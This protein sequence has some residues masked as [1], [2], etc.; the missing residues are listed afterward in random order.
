MDLST[1][2]VVI[3]AGGRGARFDHETQ[4]KP[5][6]MIEVCGKP[7]LEHIID[8]FVRQGFRE[9]WIA[10]G[11]LVEQIFEFF[12]EREWDEFES[13][14]YRRDFRFDDVRIHVVDTGELSHTGERVRIVAPRDSR[15][16]LTYGDGLSDVNMRD[17]IAQHLM[18]SAVVTTVAVRPPN[19]FGVVEF[20]GQSTE[21]FSFTEKP[22]AGWINGGFMVCE[23]E[24]AEMFKPY[25]GLVPELERD[26]MYTLATQGRL[27]AFRHDSFWHCIDSRRDLENLELRV[28]MDDSDT[29]PWL[30]VRSRS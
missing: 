1:I 29:L 3:L 21:V 23:P 5:K 28:E 2:P 24:L 13:F 27:H 19:R 11:Y 7:L 9:F 4:L 15:F 17:V 6:P 20:D 22:Q 14:A 8:G 30:V 10:G 18:T 25:E 12:A 16:V 26:V